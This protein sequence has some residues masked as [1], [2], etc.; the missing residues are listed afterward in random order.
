MVSLEDALGV[1]GDA[2][3]APEHFDRRARHAHVHLGQRML[4][5][6]R[7]VV[8]I[9]IDVVVDDDPRHLPFCVLVVVLG[10]RPHGRLVHLCEGAG[11]TAGQLLEGTL[12]QVGQQRAQRPVKFVQT[13][14]ALVAQPRQHPARDHQHAVLHLGLVPRPAST[15]RQHR[16][17]IVLG[18]VLVSGVDVRL[19]AR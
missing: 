18:Q 16:H 9:D 17:A 12:V 8:A 15:C 2:L 7:V 6:H 11:V 14:E 19:V 4:A 3:T 1:A 5:R 10:Q 13:K